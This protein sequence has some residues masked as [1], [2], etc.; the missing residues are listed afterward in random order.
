MLGTA[1][2][3]MSESAALSV[4]WTSCRPARRS[5][6][7]RWASRYHLLR[8]FELALLSVRA[9]AALYSVFG[10]LPTKSKYVQYVMSRKSIT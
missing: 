1:Y 3:G 8:Y 9:L 6:R 7:E 10:V 4:R 5:H 2:G